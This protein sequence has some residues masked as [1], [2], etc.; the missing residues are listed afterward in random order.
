MLEADTSAAALAKKLRRLPLGLVSLGNGL[1]IEGSPF[2][3]QVGSEVF[4]GGRKLLVADHTEIGRRP[5]G[6]HIQEP[7]E[8]GRFRFDEFIQ[9]DEEHRFEFE[10]LDV[11]NIEH[12]NIGLIT[13]RLAIDTGNREEASALQFFGK[14]F[15]YRLHVLLRRDQNGD[16]WHRLIFGADLIFD[17]EDSLCYPSDYSL[18]LQLFSK[19]WLNAFVRGVLRQTAYGFDIPVHVLK[20]L[21]GEAVQEATLSIDSVDPLKGEARSTSADLDV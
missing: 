4:Q 6:P 3:G 1:T 18:T 12:P 20:Q 7:L 10:P 11:L 8:Q 5:S 2:I 13:Q 9:P 19:H 21:D 17:L 15:S 14:R 16:R